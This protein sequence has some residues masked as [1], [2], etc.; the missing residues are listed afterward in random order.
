MITATFYRKGQ[1]YSGFCV[2]GHAEHEIACACVSSAVQMTANGITETAGVSAKVEAKGDTVR[3]RLTGQPDART[4]VL[5]GAL[6]QHCL[7]LVEDFPGRIQVLQKEG[8]F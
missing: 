1:Q 4:E 8:S 3:L 6:Y 5:M 2:S 7:C